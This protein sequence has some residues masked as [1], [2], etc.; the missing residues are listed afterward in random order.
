MKTSN[1]L[2]LIAFAILLAGTVLVILK[3]KQFVVGESIEM[4]GTIAN[5]DY[6]ISDIEVLNIE[7][8]VELEIIKSGNNK[9]TLDADSSVLKYITVT[10]TDKMLKIKLN[11][12]YNK[13][14]KV[15]GTLNINDFAFKSLEIGAGAQVSS[16]DTL[17]SDKLV[18]ELNAGGR[19]NIPVSCNQLECEANAGA[20]A[21]LSGKTKEFKTSA[22]AGA[23]INAGMLETEDTRA[24]ANAGGFVLVKVS[25]S[26]DVHCSAGGTVKYI[27]QPD[28]KNI[29]INSG[30]NLSKAEL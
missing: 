22:N 5:K 29:D 25:K 18:I 9:L 28:M 27:G 2:L 7:G 6:E 17:V 15:H 12:L 13:H 19:I 3:V 20:G 1:K 8:P 23:Q 4:S 10:Q 21:D 11:T 16:V 26:L 30:G 24:E 14:I